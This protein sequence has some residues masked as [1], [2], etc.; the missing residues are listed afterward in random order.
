MTVLFFGCKDRM[1][2]HHWDVNGNAIDDHAATPWGV[3]IDSAAFLPRTTSN[4]G[5]ARLWHLDGWTALCWHDRTVDPRPGSMGALLVDEVHSAE[6][7]VA[8]LSEHFP[9]IAARFAEHP[10]AVAADG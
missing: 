10:I 1:G 7:C 9:E 5:A 4:T 3:R 8:L 6:E 2:H